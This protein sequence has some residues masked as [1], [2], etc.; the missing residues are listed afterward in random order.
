MNPELAVTRSVFFRNQ[1]MIRR[2]RFGEENVTCDGLRTY[3]R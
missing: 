3:A 2:E 1:E